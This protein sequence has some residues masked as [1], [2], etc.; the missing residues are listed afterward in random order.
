MKINTIV[1]FFLGVFTLIISPINSFSQSDYE[2]QTAAFSIDLANKI[3]ASNKTRVAVSDFLD[4]DGNLTELGKAIAEDIGVG[5]VNNGNGVFQVMERSNLNAILKEQKLSSTGLIDPETAKKLG[6]L[7]MV[8]AVIVG[9]ITPFGN[10]FRVTIKILDTETGM[11]IA[12]A[13]GNIAGTDDIKGLFAKK[14]MIFGQSS[15]S[16]RTDSSTTET[17]SKSSKCSKCIGEGTIFVKGPC[18]DCKGTGRINCLQCSGTGQSN[19]SSR[20]RKSTRLNS[21]HGGISRMPS[22]A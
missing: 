16:L 19:T 8:D 10:S 4:N 11:S 15:N 7:K 21:S 17:N 13:A 14:V 22:S 1:I 9:N 5:I 2:K 3:K 6:K 20:D 12:A 18:I